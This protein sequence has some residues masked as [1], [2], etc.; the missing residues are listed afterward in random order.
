MADRNELINALY[1]S[2]TG[3]DAT[4]DDS[5]SCSIYNASTG[6]LYCKF[7]DKELTKQQIDH[8]VKYMEDTYIVLNANPLMV[9]KAAYYR[10]AL[11]AIRLMIA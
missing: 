1:Q 11:E 7:D 3:K 9:E 8:A 5:D 4:K 2:F 6:T 10:I